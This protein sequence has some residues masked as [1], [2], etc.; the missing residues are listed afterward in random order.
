M[1]LFLSFF[2]FFETESPS[3]AR[4]ECSGAIPAHCNFCFPVSSNSPASASQVTGTTDVNHHTWLE[5]FFTVL[6]IHTVT[7]SDP[8]TVPEIYPNLT[9][10]SCHKTALVRV[11]NDV[12]IAESIGFFFF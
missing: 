5:N 11:T 3:I 1:L 10:Y 9:L 6:S 12:D 2:F 8:S 4:L 7:P